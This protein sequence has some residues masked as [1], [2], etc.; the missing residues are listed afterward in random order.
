VRPEIRNP[1][2]RASRRS[3]VVQ[4]AFAVLITEY[5]AQAEGLIADRPASLEGIAANGVETT[6]VS[7]ESGV[8]WG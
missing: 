6:S 5:P 7:I 2:G 4:A 8:D 3:D 1:T